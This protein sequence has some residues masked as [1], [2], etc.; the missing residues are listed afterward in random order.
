MAG[1]IKFDPSGSTMSETKKL[2]F[3]TAYNYGNIRTAPGVPLMFQRHPQH[4]QMVAKSI[5]CNPIDPY[6]WE[7]TTDY[8][9]PNYSVP[10]F[11]ETGGLKP[12]EFPPEIEVVPLPDEKQVVERYFLTEDMYWLPTGL[13]QL[14]TGK[15]FDDPPMMPIRARQITINWNAEEADD[16]DFEACEYTTN[17][18][19]V[20][21]NGRAYAAGTL[22]MQMCYFNPAR[23][24]DG[25]L[26]YKCTAQILYRPDGHHFR[27]LF[28]DWEAVF[29]GKILPVWKIKET[30]KWGPPPETPADGDEK[31]T[32][33][34]LLGET[35]ALL[36]D[37]P[38][39]VSTLTPVFGDFQ[40]YEEGD[41]SV[42]EMPTAIGRVKRR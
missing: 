40:I 31:V 30:G 19:S 37:D 14:P 7:I 2:R 35:G 42:L 13:I 24:D 10:D 29:D 8:E 41:W 11:P 18:A 26:Y 38:A 5:S 9:I 22:Y 23:D 21:I 28:C 15:P 12:W 32:E 20:T 25:T 27:P 34:V 36:T 16:V 39:L 4:N 6:N 33:K 3:A 17:L 1:S